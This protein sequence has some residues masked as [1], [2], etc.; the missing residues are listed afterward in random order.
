MGRFHRLRNFL[1]QF[2]EKLGQQAIPRQPLAVSRVEKLFANDSLLIDKEIPRAG[3]ALLH[4][5]GFPVQDAVGVDDFGIGVAEQRVLDPVAGGKISQDFFG[6][7]TDGRQLDSLLF[8]SWE[9][10]L[11]LDQLPFAERSP[12][13]GT[14]KQQHRAVCSLQAV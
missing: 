14:E 10:A 1:P 2:R 6:V 3:K 7:I 5:G 12:V 13:R 4:S 11:Q 8:E 9:C